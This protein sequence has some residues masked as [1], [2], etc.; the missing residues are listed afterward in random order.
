M[1]LKWAGVVVTSAALLASTGALIA[2]APSW[3]LRDQISGTAGLF[4]GMASFSLAVWSATRQAEASRQVRDAEARAEA[5]RLAHEQLA[6]EN[7]SKLRA[8][9]EALRQGQD[10]ESQPQRRGVEIQTRRGNIIRFYLAIAGAV[11]GTALA[12]TAFIGGVEMPPSTPPSDFAVTC[13]FKVAATTPGPTE[14][15]PVLIYV[16]ADVTSD[17][18]I[19][20][21]ISLHVVGNG[22]F[23]YPNRPLWQPR[24][25]MLLFPG[26]GQR[27]Y[28]EI[29]V[30]GSEMLQ[31]YTIVL[32]LWPLGEHRTALGEATCKP[33]E[34]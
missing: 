9:E 26:T 3:E 30:E 21:A 28:D 4:I 27:F 33:D 32:R 10:A 1:S 29:R 19:A 7:A 13:R 24:R 14:T 15:R 20:V 2:A 18:G 16:V 22:G 8:L 34:D 12:A 25:W 23:E 11:G 17:S 5:E 31:S 6:T